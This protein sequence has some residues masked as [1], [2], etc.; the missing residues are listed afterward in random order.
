MNKAE[1]GA[2]GRAWLVPVLP[3]VLAAFLTVLCHGAA[4]TVPLQGDDKELFKRLD[5]SRVHDLW[6]RLDPASSRD[7]RTKLY[8]PF[9]PV[10]DATYTALA[11]VVGARPGPFHVA[12]LCFQFANCLL[13]YAV[14]VRLFRSRRAALVAMAVFASSPTQVEAVTYTKN[15]AET[16]A[17]C[18]LLVSFTFA[19]RALD[20]SGRRT[21]DAVLATVFYIAAA[22]TKESAWPLPF[23]LL[24]WLWTVRPEGARRNP[25]LAVALL[26]PM[27]IVAGAW[28][29][30]QL[31]LHGRGS[32]P[33][34]PLSA[35]TR[36]ELAGRTTLRYLG[37]LA[38]PVW[39]RY[40]AAP[41]TPHA[42]G[43][44]VAGAAAAFLLLILLSLRPG[45]AARLSFG[46]WWTLLALGPVSNLAPANTARPFAWQRLYTPSVG[47][48]LTLGALLAGWPGRG[49][50]SRR[51]R[52]WLD[53]LATTVVAAG[54]AGCIWQTM[55]WGTELRLWR[56]VVRTCPESSQ[57]QF[58]LGLTLRRAD[59]LPAAVA[60]YR[61]SLAVRPDNADAVYNMANALFVLHRFRQAEHLFRCAVKLRKKFYR[62]YN[63]LGGALASQA[64]WREAEQA[65][66]AALRY[67]P[68]SLL[69]ANSLLRIY[70][71]QGRHKDMESLTRHALP[72][73]SRN[74]ELLLARAYALL[75]LDR[76]PEAVQLLRRAV[77]SGVK[78]RVADLLQQLES[79]AAP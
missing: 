40:W 75:K 74:A 6:R 46:L 9:R 20:S 43:Y 30:L 51:H 18:L 56:Y 14:A 12:S 50:R 67:S 5:R 65:F 19:V 41:P 52:L 79:E 27:F 15:I 54:I 66:R 23:L 29:W 78:G 63:G 70:R 57:P 55:R 64:R 11:L 59:L 48:A 77:R 47:F 53:A 28:A 26:A 10:R 7:P 35:P 22:L 25:R 39:P 36:A 61:L 3:A 31:D 21:R 44:G 69:A 24:A 1:R 68:E 37:A 17:L 71:R 16:Q 45:P 62:A 73:A 8:A 32:A 49:S 42:P 33:A 72:H 60:H 2:R 34:A 13:V 58:N 76:R 38:F 4:I